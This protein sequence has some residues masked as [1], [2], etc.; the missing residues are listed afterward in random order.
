MYKVRYLNETNEYIYGTKLFKVFSNREIH[1]EL[2]DDDEIVAE[3]PLTK[4]DRCE[5]FDG[6]DWVKFKEVD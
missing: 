1:Y 2:E 3:I 4:F 5:K 6:F